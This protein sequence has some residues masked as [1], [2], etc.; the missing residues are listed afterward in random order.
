MELSDVRM[1]VGK[2]IHN[3][4]KHC[5]RSLCFHEI[6]LLRYRHD[7]CVYANTIVRFNLGE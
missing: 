6:K 3:G 4:L 1:R 2:R 7:E 5:V